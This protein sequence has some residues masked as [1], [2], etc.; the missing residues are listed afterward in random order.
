MSK[1]IYERILLGLSE[2]ATHFHPRISKTFSGKV[3]RHIS[4]GQH[5]TIALDDIGQV[6]VMGR[7]EYGRLGLG[8]NCSDAKEL[9]LVSALSSMKCIDIS[10]GSAQSFAV[11]ELGMTT[12][13]KP[14]MISKY[15]KTYYMAVVGCTIFSCGIHSANFRRTICVGNGNEWTTRHRRRRRRRRACASQRKAIRRQNG[16]T[17]FWW[18]TA[19]INFS[20]NSPSER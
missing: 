17:S 7:K 12:T 14:L 15:F 1:E 18:W 20:D 3:W 11:T 6:F 13:K 9:T 16:G 2:P 4:S 10:A 5:H 8:P 19:Y